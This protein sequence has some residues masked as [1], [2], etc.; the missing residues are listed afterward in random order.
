MVL[1]L[2][3]LDVGIISGMI[4]AAVALSKHLMSPGMRYD[5]V[6]IS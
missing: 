3:A 5:F 2:S 1:A 6:R 4:A